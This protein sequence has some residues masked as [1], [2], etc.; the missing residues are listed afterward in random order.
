MRL[1]WIEYLTQTKVFFQ[2]FFFSLSCNIN[3]CFNSCLCVC[4]DIR[5]SGLHD[6][7][8]AGLDWQIRSEF[9]NRVG[10]TIK[11]EMTFPTG[12]AKKKRKTNNIVGQSRPTVQRW[13]FQ[14]GGKKNYSAKDDNK[15]L[16]NV[17]I[18][19]CIK[20]KF[21]RCVQWRYTHLNS[22]IIPFQC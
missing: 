18:N 17:I 14:T 1:S 19:L 22:L 2:F 21:F 15:F 4:K 9:S 5:A 8:L 20:W 6:P 3:I 7:H 12:W 10:H 16:I 13:S 11:R